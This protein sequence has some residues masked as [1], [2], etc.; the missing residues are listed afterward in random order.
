MW[1]V[2]S[3]PPVLPWGGELPGVIPPPLPPL[4]TKGLNAPGGLFLRE[5]KT[6]AGML[7]TIPDFLTE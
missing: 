1:D 5:K 6:P 3:P 4:G 7:V 2:F